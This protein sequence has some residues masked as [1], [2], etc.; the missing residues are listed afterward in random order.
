MALRERGKIHGGNIVFPK[1]LALPEGTEVLVSI[2]PLA[3]K[4]QTASSGTEEDFAALPFFGMWR[5]PPACTLGRRRGP[6]QGVL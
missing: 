5:D 6:P 3:V 1:P 4:E 2:E